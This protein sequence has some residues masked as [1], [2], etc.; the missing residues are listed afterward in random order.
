MSSARPLPG[1]LESLYRHIDSVP[2]T[3]IEAHFIVSVSDVKQGRAEA[4]T[5]DACT[6]SAMPA[7]YNTSLVIKFS[8]VF[9]C[10]LN[11]LRQGHSISSYSNFRFFVPF[12]LC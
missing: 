2:R 11:M 12:I 5:T 10:H 1:V 4:S 6:M 8:P 7:R 9:E 3:F